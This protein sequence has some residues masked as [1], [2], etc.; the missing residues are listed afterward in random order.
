MGYIEDFAEKS[1]V[2]LRIAKKYFKEL[3]DAGI[4]WQLFDVETIAEE[5]QDF[6]QTGGRLEH[7]ELRK[8][9][10]LPEILEKTAE[11]ETYEQEI[12]SQ[13]YD[14]TGVRNL[15]ERVYSDKNLTTKQK[16]ELKDRIIG[17]A[18]EIVTLLALYNGKEKD[19]AKQ[20]LR[21]MVLSP[22]AEIRDFLKYDTLKIKSSRGWITEINDIPLT[23]KVRSI[24]MVEKLQDYN[25]AV[26]QP[27]KEYTTTV[28][29]KKEASQPVLKPVEQIPPVAKVIKAEAVETT[30]EQIIS[31]AEEFAIPESQTATGGIPLPSLEF[32]YRCGRKVLTDQ[33]SKKL[34]GQIAYFCSEF[35]HYADKHIPQREIPKYGI[36]QT[37]SKDTVSEMRKKAFEK[38]S[39]EMK[40]GDKIRYYGM[41]PGGVMTSQIHEG[42]IIE[43][44]T[45]DL[46]RRIGDIVIEKPDGTREAITKRRIVK[47]TQFISKT[48]EIKEFDIHKE[49]TK[50]EDDE[51]LRRIGAEKKPTDFEEQVERLKKENKLRPRRKYGRL[52]WEYRN[53]DGIYT[54][55]QELEEAVTKAL[56]AEK[57]PSDL[58]LKKTTTT[59]VIESHLE[60]VRKKA[61]E[62]ATAYSY[63]EIKKLGD[64]N[65]LRLKGNKIEMLSELIRKNII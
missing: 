18:P 32:C 37:V 22:T 48:G 47:P 31:V 43:F 38:K 51:F 5:I 58:Y 12:E 13:L 52:W 53:K 50:K 24:D 65:N 8:R 25:I 55:T 11:Q 20:F 29:T 1:G 30:P 23:K 6:S 59:E 19:Y 57:E 4:D 46:D 17:G 10:G 64:E 21:E 63:G 27:S 7:K 35:C 41:M 28:Y 9:L 54:M 40:I 34:N 3:E 62:L 42:K 39:D 44:L 16:N 61:E 14:K 49:W 2:D 45:E 26:S 56:K 15:L 60:N 33:Y 36:G